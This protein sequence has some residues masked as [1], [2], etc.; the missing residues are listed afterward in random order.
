MPVLLPQYL[1]ASSVAQTIAACEAITDGNEPVAVVDC[2]QLRFV[3]PLGIALLG[4]TFDAIRHQARKIEILNLSQD[5][6]GY[7]TRMDLFKDLELV[8]EVPSPVGHR[9]D[10]SSDLVE[11]TCLSDSNQ[12]DDA[13]FRL[14]KT[15]IGQLDGIDPNEPVDPMTCM[16]TWDRTLEPIRYTLSELLENALTHAR[17]AGYKYAKVWVASQY[18]QKRREIHLGVVDDG[19][20]F[21]GS[22]EKHPELKQQRHHDAIL[23][24]LRPRVSCNRDQWLQSKDSVNQGVG[25]TTSCRIAEKAGGSLLLTSGNAFHNTAGRSGELPYDAHWQGVAI[26]FRCRRDML[27]GFRISELLPPLDAKLPVHLRFE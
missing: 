7:L 4:A 5:L 20:G 9:H 19:C 15:I 10:R 2:S 14:A 22:L 24:A 23:L 25:L 11:L 12:V 21:L 16:N 26:A 17:R 13:A 8:G 1:S 27:T 6:Q 3:D 18:Y